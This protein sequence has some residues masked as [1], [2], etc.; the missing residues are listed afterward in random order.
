ML[1]ALHSWPASAK[2]AVALQRQLARQVVLQPLPRRPQLIAGADVGYRPDDS[3]VV[4]AVAVYRLPQLELQE[5]LTVEDH[6]SFPY[7]PGLLS[8]REI[9]SLLK[10]FE[11]LQ[12]Q[13]DIVLCDGQGVAHPRRL[14]LASHLGLWLQVPTV[15]CAKSRLVG[16]HGRVGE[17]RGQYRSLMHA[18][19]RLGV[20]LRTR[21]RVKP[22]YISPGHLADVDS[23]MRLVLRCCRRFRLPE[24]IRR[25]HLTVQ[26][27]VHSRAAT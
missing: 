17:N 14:G 27:E 26:R 2:K 19:E 7:V 1:S 18:G 9:P 12:L 11:H 5:L 4:A 25:A 23:S 24:P 16:E 15:G 20:V 10:A 6:V 13:P 8:F 21:R 3:K 22:L